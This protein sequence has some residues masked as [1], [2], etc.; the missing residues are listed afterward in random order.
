MFINGK[1]RLP[2]RFRL[3]DDESK[4][5]LLKVEIINST[6]PLSSLKHFSVLIFCF[7]L[8]ALISILLNFFVQWKR[9]KTLS[10]LSA[11]HQTNTQWKQLADEHYEAK[12]S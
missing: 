5:M 8:V 6:V 7:A 3:I 9:A 4:S 10:T 1:I 12:Q 2:F 11:K